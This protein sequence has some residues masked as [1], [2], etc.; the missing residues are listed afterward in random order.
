MAALIQ[1]LKQRGLLDET[2]VVWGVGVRPHPARAGRGGA[3]PPP[4]SPSR[5][6]MA[7]GGVQA[8]LRPRRDGRDRLGPGPRS[9]PRERLPR[10]LLHLF[11]LDHLR[12][13]YRYQGL[14]QRLTTV[15][16]E[17]RVVPELL[18]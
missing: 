13:T 16:R 7:G 11:G 6:F 10:H 8:G 2:L 14:D 1:D 18:A 15:T 4:L 5:I 9:G 12:L 3:R 17:A